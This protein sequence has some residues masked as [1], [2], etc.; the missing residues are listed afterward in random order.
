MWIQV[1]GVEIL[2]SQ[3]AVFAQSMG[4]V[5]GNV[6]EIHVE[7]YAN[8]DIFLIGGQTGFDAEASKCAKLAAGFLEKSGFKGRT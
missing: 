4:K 3:S 2:H 1:G 5:K 8:H 7:P 6:V